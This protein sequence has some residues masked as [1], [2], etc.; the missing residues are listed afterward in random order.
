MCTW[1][2]TLVQWGLRPVPA[3]VCALW[4]PGFPLTGK[5]TPEKA[6]GRRALSKGRA[7]P[8]PRRAGTL[9]IVAR[10]LLFDNALLPEPLP[11]PPPLLPSYNPIHIFELLDMNRDFTLL[12]DGP[13]VETPLQL[14]HSGQQ[15][16]T[17]VFDS[18]VEVRSQWAGTLL[19]GECST[20]VVE[21]QP[22]G[23]LVI[24]QHPSGPWLSS[25]Q[26]RTD[27]WMNRQG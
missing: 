3:I 20:G 15:P 4:L 11:I 25:E 18:G 2:P 17:T 9:H 14:M 10:A 16:S 12:T 5:I 1:E 27:E 19:N 26:T 7:L 22:Q 6:L 23:Q 21:S 8:L 13:A 24:T